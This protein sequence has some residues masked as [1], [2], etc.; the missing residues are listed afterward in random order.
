MFE[1]LDTFAEV[2]LND[3]VIGNTDNF[4]RTWA[5][6]VD[7]LK[8]SNNTILIRFWSALRHN[9]EE[10]NTLDHLR[11]PEIFSFSRKPAFHFGWDWGA[12][13]TTCGI[14]KPV[15]L[16]GHSSA[17]ILSTQFSNDPIE[18]PTDLYK[19]YHQDPSTVATTSTHLTH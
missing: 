17:R 9:E 3:E 15:Y 6:K 8:E 4:F 7:S 16:I 12:K 14:F 1:G 13:L 10:R 18:D 19:Q 5:F 2:K 11:L